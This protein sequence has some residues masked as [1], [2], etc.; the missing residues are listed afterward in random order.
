[1][2]SRI[3]FFVQMGYCTLSED[4]SKVHI[5]YKNL[6]RLILLLDYFGSLLTPLI[7]TYQVVLTA[8]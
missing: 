7:D 6:E 1:M 5:V 2:M 8:I 3:A 4:H